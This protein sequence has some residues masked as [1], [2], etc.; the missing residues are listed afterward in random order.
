MVIVLLVEVGSHTCAGPT[1]F[2]LVVLL[3]LCVYLMGNKGQSRVGLGINVHLMN[4]VIKI[5][6]SAL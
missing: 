3:N 1:T 2:V 5:S 6:F 4:I